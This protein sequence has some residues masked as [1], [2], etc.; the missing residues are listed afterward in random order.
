MTIN[1]IPGAL[2][3]HTSYSDGSG[4]V[5]DL[6]RAARAA[7]LRWI[8]ITDHDTLAGQ[9]YEGWL[10]GVL[11]IIDHEI[12]P[13]RNHFLALNVDEVIDNTL[14]PQDFVDAVYARGGFGIIAHPDERVRN[15]FKNIYRWDDWA[16]DGPRQRA[17][18]PVGIELWNQLSDWGE[19][20]TQRNK[21]LHV[22]RPRLGM[23]GPTRETL[24]WWDRLNVSGKRTFGVGGVD[25]HAFKKRAP[26]GEIEIFSYKW[27]FGTLTNYLLLDT[28]LAPDAP[29]AIH[30]VYGAL[31]AGRSYFVNRYDGACPRLVFHAQQ[32]SH[33][34]AAGSSASL[35]DGPL[36]ITADAGRAA[37]LRLIHNGRVVAAARRAL[38][39][40]LSTPGVFRL[41]GY[42]N[43]RAW[44]FSN[45]IYVTE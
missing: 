35:S 40:E 3:M 7:G 45:P 2:H 39:Y 30:Q 22:L 23:R 9:P 41:E 29:S 43:G 4:S 32:G 21:E 36:T 17:G 25:A 44:L 19:H 10:D 26:W 8:I 18:K 14:P 38:R 24:A 28:P 37:V 34:Y 27:T 31:A 42:R 1:Y 6:A 20:L 13:D 12:T 15:D 16:V 11:V 5:E 33:Y